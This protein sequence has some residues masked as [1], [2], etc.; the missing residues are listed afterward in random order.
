MFTKEFK[1]H[2]IGETVFKR[3]RNIEKLLEISKIYLKFE[4][5]NPTGTMKDRAS[6]ATLKNA[7]EKEFDTIAVASCGNLGASIVRLSKIFS[8][9]PHVYIPESYQTPRISEMERQGGHIH[10]VPGTYE[11]LVEYSSKESE[12]K[13]WYNGNPGTKENTK[14][15]LIAYESLSYEIFD[16]LK[17]AP[18]AVSVATSNGTCFSGIYQGWKKLNH[19]GLTDKLPVMVCASTTGGNPIISSYNKGK[20]KIKNL[21]PD[22]IQETSLNEPIV[23]WKSLDGQIALDAL[24]DSGGYAVGVEDPILIAFSEILEKEEGFSV[25]PASASALAAM[26]EY[27]KER[28]TPKEEEFVVVLTSRKY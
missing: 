17:Y 13:G 8:I 22:R 10:R 15:S 28:A 24:W 2:G 21:K 27:I 16:G 1:E 3:S 18:D 11:E 5:G 26:S 9:T 19:R 20:R 14:A 7:Y 4:G 25:L 12:E 23:N 6:Y